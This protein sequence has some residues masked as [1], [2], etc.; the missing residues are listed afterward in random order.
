MTS[1][2]IYVRI[3]DDR[4]GQQT[5]TERQRADCER[6]AESHGWEVVDHFS[7]VDL[8][9][10]QRRTKRPEFDRMIEAVRTH[11][12]DGVLAWKLD[13]ITRRQRDL[14]R[15]DEACEDAGGF[16]ATVVDAIDTRSSTGRFVAELLTAQARMESENSSIRVKR[17]HIERVAKGKPGAGGSRRFGYTRQVEV[18][19]IEAALIREARDR[20]FAGESMRGIARDW[21]DRGVVTP[22]G[23]RWD[24]VALR[25]MLMGAH[26]SAQREHLGALTPGIWTPILA[27]ADTTRIRAILSDPSRVHARPAGRSYLLTGFARCGR[28]GQP[29]RGAPNARHR[30]YACVKQLDRPNCGG[31]ARQADPVDDLVTQMLFEA[32][33]GVDLREYL[34]GQGDGHEQRIA[35]EVRADEA[36]L[37]ELSADFYVGR[38]ISR[39]QFVT[40]QASLNARLEANRA[41]LSTTSAGSMLATIDAG[42]GLERQWAGETLEWKRAVIGTIIESITIN[43][44]AVHGRHAFDP[45]AIIVKWK[46]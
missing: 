45:T 19:E 6:F 39:S 14:V 28:C 37:N 5:A 13:R 36:A 4:D 41:R 3:S 40:A 21:H 8:S 38:T 15:L 22:Q 11:A 43:P 1:V 17:K 29:L 12:V 18:I 34:E 25:R 9:A 2:G 30:R 20:L 27:P 24:Q 7:D 44:P 46:F 42:E 31:I 23:N 10:F 32:L 16:I 35:E 26:L 33:R